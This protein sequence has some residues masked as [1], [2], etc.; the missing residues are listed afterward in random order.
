MKSLILTTVGAGLLGTL[1]M[2]CNGS[3]NREAVGT[4][5]QALEALVPL[6]G[7]GEVE[8]YVRERYVA[9]VNRVVDQA[10]AQIQKSE[11]GACYQGYDDAPTA[12]AAGGSSGSAPSSSPSSPKASESSGTNNQVA[13]V[14][15]ADF[16]KNDGQYLYIV[17]NGALRI[18]KAFPANEAA[19]VSKVAI[20]GTPKKLFVEG[21]RA[22]VYTSVPK[23]GATTPSSGYGDYSGRSSECTTATTAFPPATAPPP[24]SSSSTSRTA[25]PP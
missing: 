18:L 2:A 10:I 11:R 4:S 25:R 19:S 15:E 16:V 22:L 9:E 1:A 17:A 3:A 20:E 5:Q 21:D 13:G 8:T 14:D 12:G 23:T 24:G 6:Q 7:C